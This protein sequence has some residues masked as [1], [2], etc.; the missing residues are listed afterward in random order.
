MNNEAKAI[1]ITQCLQ[2]DFISAVENW[3]PLPNLL[4]I[5]YQ[6]SSR[7]MG[8]IPL[9]G[10]VNRVMSW[11]Y[12]TSADDLKLIHI[13]D[14]H[15]Q[16]D[17]AQSGHLNTFGLH[18]MQNTKGA[19]FI[20]DEKQRKSVS[21]IN[22][23]GL[24]DF[25]DTNLAEILAPWANSVFRV[26]L[27]GVWTDA[28][29]SFLAYE[30]V[31]RYPNS[32]VAVCS[33]LTASTSRSAHFTA[34][35]SIKNILGIEVI[36]SPASFCK[37]LTGS[38]PIIKKRFADKLQI[39]IKPD[40]ALEN[41]DR[42]LIGFLFRDS[43]KVDLK[44]LDGGFSGNLV[45]KSRSWDQFGRQQVPG[46]IK[47]GDR[48]LI[49][50][51][52][53][54][55]ERIQEVMG[56]SAPQITEF[57]DRTHRGGIKY[58][59][60]SMGSENVTV[61]Q[62]LY[63]NS[64]I[65]KLHWVLDAVFLNQLGRL[66]SAVTA[67]KTDLFSYWDFNPRYSSSIQSKIE[68]LKDV[69]IKDD[70]ILLEEQK[71][72]N[73][74]KFYKNDLKD[75]RFNRQINQPFAWVH[76]DLNGR[77]IIIDDQNNVWLIDFF[78]THYGH[79]LRDLIKLENDIMFIFTQINSLEEFR[80]ARQFT[81]ILFELEDLGA[82]PFEG[83]QEEIKKFPEDFQK[84]SKVIQILRGY[85]SEMIG[86]MRDPLAW[87]IAILR[88]AMHTLSFDES[89]SWQKKWALY[90][91]SKSVDKIRT[92]LSLWGRIRIDAIEIN[93]KNRLGLTV[94]PGR[95]DWQH[96]LKLDIEVIKNQNYKAVVCL[97]PDQEL[98]LYG[99]GDLIDSYNNAGIQYLHQPVFDQGVPSN[100]Q[101]HL[102]SDW[103]DARF[104]ENQNVLVHCVGGLG[105][106][107]T[108][109]ACYLIDKAGYNAQAAIAK[110]R[111][112]RSNRAIESLEQENFIKQY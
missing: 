89:N 101:A 10:P 19:E 82:N 13:R 90:T 47:I 29:I 34:L 107:G 43:V 70:Y 92:K 40:M 55:F 59:Y 49:A 35:D 56:N 4:H 53:E 42:E 109:A 6:E 74:V 85:Y 78:H 87:H 60:A 5:G 54:S 80:T 3:Q 25:V 99:V 14:W 63:K 20:F 84:C 48:D 23:S 24:N 58:R 50:K 105:R 57:A 94:L 76:G 68:S 111:A 65:S 52:R 44:A 112:V 67:E 22:A 100:D 106:S 77:N 46:I 21:I 38:E 26:G 110:V 12:N 75:L 16:N 95:K 91:G 81:D 8:E 104:H 88:Y 97:V 28:K 9:D 73:V 102:I 71:I 72:T 2:N 79:V 66:Y 86:M 41:V 51:E 96:D 39:T 108:I 1:L 7:L 11:A 83:H 18:C 31:T 61:F 36:A 103:I 69:E 98:K 15:D 45:L 62:D 64:K 32:R 37:F 30:L 17:P 27:I 33:A 93:G